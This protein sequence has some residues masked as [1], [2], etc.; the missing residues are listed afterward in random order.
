LAHGFVADAGNRDAITR[1]LDDAAA[2]RGPIDGLFLNAATPGLFVPLADYTDEAL[3]ELLQ[4]DV[5]GPFYAIRHVAP[6]MAAR[7]RGSILV[8]GSLAS[9]RGMVGNPGY[10]VA[11][12]AVLGLARAAAME[13]AGSGVRCNCINP[14]YI[15][16]PML[17]DVPAE[18]LA[19]LASLVPQQ[20]IGQPE[21]VAEV[22]AFLLSDASSHVTAQSWAV[23]G[24]VLGTLL[25]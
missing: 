5:K 4:V 20:R 24:G 7:G 11:K 10:L 14:G 25:Q 18:V 17:Q 2:A 23:D 12:H 1:A 16:T 9:E 19:R 13:F 3:D 6:L 22:A 21:E 15:D 8:T